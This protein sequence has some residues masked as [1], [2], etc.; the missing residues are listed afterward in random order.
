LIKV[1]INRKPVEGPWGGGNM[2][3]KSAYDLL[4]RHDIKI[5]EINEDPDAII[6]AGLGPETNSISALQAIQYKK[7]AALKGKIVK[8]MLRVNENDARKGTTGV[9][10]TLRNISV[11]IDYTVF[12]SQWLLQYFENF[13]WNCKNKKFIHNGVDGRVFYS[14]K[15][16]NGEKIKIV[17]HHWS[18]NYMKG[19]DVYEEI[20]KWV[21]D[22]SDFSFTYIGRD[23]GTFKNTI[24][25][26]PLFG[27]ELGDELSRYD[28]YVSASR[29]DPGPNHVLE[30]LSCGIPT[31]V[32]ADGGGAVEFAGNQN[33]YKNSEEILNILL[34][35]KYNKNTWVPP[36]WEECMA[37]FADSIKEIL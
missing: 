2:W 33:S 5:V 15:E 26:P 32:H 13:G 20:D 27:K 14:Q 34:S 6:I 36:T 29:F 4:P 9:D 37:K 30:S 31:Y 22:R 25:I 35:K 16:K 8:L 12:V 7:W 17:T 23:R 11:H 28:V 19:F 24:H 21:K 1:H 18:D 10:E 3:I